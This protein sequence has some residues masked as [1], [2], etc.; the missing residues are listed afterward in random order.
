MVS[1]IFNILFLLV[2]IYCLLKVIGFALYEI[3]EMNNKSGGIIVISFSILVIIFAN[4]VIW[5]N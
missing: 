3:K 4:F 2:S 5:T 1:L